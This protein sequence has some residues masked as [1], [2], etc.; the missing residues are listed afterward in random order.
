MNEVESE[1]VARRGLG[2][3]KVAAICGVGVLAGVGGAVAV[4]GGYLTQAHAAGQSAAPQPKTVVQ[5]VTPAPKAPE[6]QATPALQKASQEV[7]VPDAANEAEPAA[8]DHK[9]T[10]ADLE[11]DVRSMA[12]RLKSDIKE[13]D[14]TSFL[15]PGQTIFDES[16]QIQFR[17]PCGA[18]VYSGSGKTF[19]WVDLEQT[20]KGM[21]F[22]TL[23]PD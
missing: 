23:K 20:P 16:G 11:A 14:M 7:A 6:R 17:R 5:Q 13:V 3:I 21:L 9:N 22:M 8:Q 19:Y 1:P 10:C 4:Q 18:T 15:Q 12:D 2:A